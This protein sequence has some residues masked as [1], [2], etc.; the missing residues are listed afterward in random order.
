MKI[1][2]LLPLIGV[3]L[4]LCIIWNMNLVKVFE[5]LKN[6]NVLFL[7]LSLLIL[8]PI[9]LLK[10]LK[11]KVLIKSYDIDY[12]LSRA[13]S[14][15]MVGLSIGLVTPGRLGDNDTPRQ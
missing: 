13:I 1:S 15:W 11:W 6:V 12:S 8:I 2:S 7:V 14:A 10:T 3:A 9:V 4:F 5:I